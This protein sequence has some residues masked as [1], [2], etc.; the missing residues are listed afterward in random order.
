M[1]RSTLKVIAALGL[2]PGGLL[3]LGIPAAA[4]S[5]VTPF[6]V[7]GAIDTP[8][9]PELSGLAASRR[10]PGL[11]W[12][13]N[14]SG[15]DPALVAL[16]DRGAA[17]AVAVDGVIN[18]DWEDLASFERDG[19]PWLLIA[20][21]GDNF[22]L[23]SEVALILVPEPAPDTV[24]VPVARVLRLRYED[25]PRDCEAMA[26][27][28]PR[29]RVLLADKG[30]EPVGLYEVA[31]DAPPDSVQVARRI[32]DFPALVATP[33]PT[34]QRLG[35]AR[36]RGLATAMDL[37]ADGRRLV[38]LTYLSLS[39]FERGPTQSWAEALARPHLSERLPRLPMFESL[40]L[41]ADGRAVVVAT[42][43]R[44]ARFFRRMLPPR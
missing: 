37:S 9:L 41:D 6:V 40:A 42:E 24:R 15:N 26:V 3:A 23:R 21:T 13:I 8:V 5:T 39:L 28:V 44:P 22:S 29:G 35:A 11:L 38:V 14:D 12:A 31:L 20:D 18:H 25:G 34:V 19:Q 4:G 33:A 36:V 2:G 1:L 16:D 27:D 30:R 43:A 17:R 32:G 7:A 10:V